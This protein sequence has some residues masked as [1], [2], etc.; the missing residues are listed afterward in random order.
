MKLILENWN[1]FIDE[2]ITVQDRKPV[3]PP[4]GAYPERT[5]Q[6]QQKLQR[7]LDAVEKRMEKEPTLV[8]KI[9]KLLSSK[10]SEGEAADTAK[11]KASDIKQIIASLRKDLQSMKPSEMELMMQKIYHV[12]KKE[13]LEESTF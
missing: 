2:V 11:Q 9:A 13:K 7:F 12:M 3:P 8:D 5:P 1:N 4:P 6:E 10:I